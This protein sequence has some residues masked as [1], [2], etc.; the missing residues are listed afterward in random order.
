MNDIR[1]SIETRN[2]NATEQS[3]VIVL[4][5]RYHCN[6]ATD[7]LPQNVNQISPTCEQRSRSSSKG[8]VELKLN[9]FFEKSKFETALGTCRPPWPVG[10]V[11]Q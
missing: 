4:I 9:Q 11:C 3:T 6:N 5:R 7:R 10:C 1:T 2:D 8:N